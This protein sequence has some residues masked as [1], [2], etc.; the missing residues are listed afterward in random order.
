MANTTTTKTVTWGHGDNVLYAGTPLDANGKPVNDSTAA[1]IL[2]AD[3][4]AP[5]RTATIITAG[6]WDESVN[7]ARFHISD[8]VKTK[9]SGIAFSQ[10]PV[11]PIGTIL[12]GYVQKT[13][14]ATTEDAGI[15]KQG[16][17]VEDAEDA[18]TKAEYNG[19]LGALRTA[20]VLATP[21]EPAE[22]PAEEPE[23]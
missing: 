7:E 16:A 9:L 11:T 2:A 4:H 6:T 8:A 22:E 12:A 10:P 13:D 15:V 18:P 14:L 5:D 17:A 23:E 19:L 3:L 1:G 21:E 20:G